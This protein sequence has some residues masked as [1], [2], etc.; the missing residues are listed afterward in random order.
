MVQSNIDLQSLDSEKETTTR[1]AG[2]ILQGTQIIA[3]FVVS[4]IRLHSEQ[5]TNTRIT[6]VIRGVFIYYNFTCMTIK[7]HH[8]K[9]SH[10]IE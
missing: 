8:L 2:I 1:I 6:G 9:S 5:E 7:F 3:L 4:L 10:L